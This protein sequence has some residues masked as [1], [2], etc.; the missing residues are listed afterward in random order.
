MSIHIS[1]CESDG[2]A[3]H[4]LR[5]SVSKSVISHPPILESSSRILVRLAAVQQ[6]APDVKVLEFAPV[7]A[8]PF[9][10]FE[11]GAHVD[12]YLPSGLTRQYSLLPPNEGRLRFAVK[13]EPE[14]RGG[15]VF[16][17]DQFC[18]GDR[19]TIG[20]P[21]NNFP[22]HKEAPLSIFIAGGIGVTPFIGMIE[23]SIQIGTAWELHYRSRSRSTA[24]FL[25]LLQPHGAGLRSSFSDDQLSGG[26]RISQIVSSAPDDA[27]IYC[28]G[29]PSMIE[30]FKQASASRDAGKVHVEY[31]AGVDSP[32]IAGGYTVEFR[33]SGKATLVCPGETIL[34]VALRLGIDV[35][36][37]CS[38]GVCGSCETRVL[39]GTP[40]HKDAVLSPPDPASGKL[41]MICCSGSK[42]DLLVVDL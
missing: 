17:H 28:C 2:F 20:K 26:L 10:P 1:L 16:L 12:V 18:I 41:I 3:K 33:R 11:P 42:D 8:A 9:E 30:A 25:D 31:F 14:G 27:H 4:E 19:L 40:D 39:A 22:L 21:R 13:R 35:S 29:P 32:A 23:E 24:P 7:D 37:S 5:I 34:D 6:A 38:D 36:Y 15:S